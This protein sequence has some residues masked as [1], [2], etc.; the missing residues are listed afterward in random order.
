MESFFFYFILERRQ[1]CPARIFD[2]FL[3]FLQAYDWGDGFKLTK[4]LK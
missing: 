3:H 4:Q 2:P 1:I